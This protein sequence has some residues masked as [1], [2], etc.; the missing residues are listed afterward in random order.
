MKF[1]FLLSLLFCSVLATAQAKPN[2]IYILADDLGYG[3]V[4]C[5]GQKEIRTPNIDAMAASGIKFTRHYAGAPVCAP[6]RAVLMTGRNIGFARVRGNYENGPYGFG[7]GLE[8][9]D[10]DL[11]IA[12][13]MKARGYITAVIGKWGMGMNGTTGEPNKQGFDYSYGFLNQGHAH[14]QF[15]E[16]LYRNGKKFEL[17]ENKNDQRKLYSN[18]LFTEEALRFVAKNKQKPFFLYL[19]YTTPHAELLVPDDSIFHSYKGKFQEK[20]YIKNGQGGAQQDNFGAYNSQ[21]YPNAAYA[22]SITHL[23]MSIGRVIAYLKSE[24]L[25]ENTLIIFSSD[26]GPAKEGGANPDYFKSSGMLRGKK[27][28]VYEGGIRVPMIA[29]W[30]SR[31][32]QG[33]VTDHVSAFEDVMTTLADAT[34][35]PLQ[36]SITTEGVSFFPLLTGNTAAQKQHKFLYWEFHEGKTSSQAMIMGK[37]KAVR[38]APDTA[39]ELYNLERD[40]AEKNNEAFNEPQLVK[41]FETM[42]KKARSPHELWPLKTNKD[43]I[44]NKKKKTTA[45]AGL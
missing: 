22:A 24:G 11:T 26:N 31:I 3:D 32:K 28:D 23:D 2:V 45:E 38:A 25:L 15:P 6:S 34:G 9:K 12:E 20:P 43:A 19:A 16:F 41:Q 39:L 17:P 4:G 30:P 18:N 10:S 5:Y 42:F 37:W 21:Q 35:K 7:A 36:K 44:S 33:V 1:F 8:L 13:V 14:Y 29:M 40:I 27:R